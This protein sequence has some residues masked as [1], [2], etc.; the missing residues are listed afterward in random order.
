MIMSNHKY[1]CVIAEFAGAEKRG[2]YNNKEE[3]TSFLYVYPKGS[4]VPKN[5]STVHSTGSM[6]Y[7]SSY[8]WLI[9]VIKKAIKEDI[10]SEERFIERLL[11]SSIEYCY[12]VFA[13]ILIK[14]EKE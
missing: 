5:W 13:N 2:E 1:N 8:D 14:H 6:Q 10:I 3:G 9:P 12:E 7:H 11:L 4:I